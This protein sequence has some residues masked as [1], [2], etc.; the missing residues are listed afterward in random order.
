MPYRSTQTPQAQ[1]CPHGSAKKARLDAKPKVDWPSEADRQ[2]HFVLRPL[3]VVLLGVIRLYQLLI[4]PLL[5]PR[6]RFYPSCSSY[7]MESIRRYGPARGFLRGVK[8]LMRCHPFAQGGVDL[9]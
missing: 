1:F 6:C 2:A 4:S 5:G 3:S 7:F 8:R 9:P